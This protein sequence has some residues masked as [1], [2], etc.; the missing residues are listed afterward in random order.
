MKFEIISGNL[1]TLALE[2]KFNAIAHGCNAYHTMGAGIAKQISR[3]WP[4]ALA[5]DKKT[6]YGDPDK[7]GDLSQVEVMIPTG[8]TL[9]IFN[10]YT[11]FHWGNPTKSGVDSKSSR[12]RYIGQ[13]A[14]AMAKICQPKGKPPISENLALGIPL[15]GAGLAGGS[16][17]TIL[18]KIKTAFESTDVNL[19]I[20]EFNPNA[21]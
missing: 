8:G 2:G 16:W 12:E 20:V 13:A 14:I 19:T 18:P 7:L 15:I 9:Y 5:A 1:I 6:P 3:T 4:Q 21:K 17:K 10:L 11:Q